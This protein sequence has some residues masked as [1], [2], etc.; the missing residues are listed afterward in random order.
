[1]AREN[2]PRLALGPRALCGFDC[3]VLSILRTGRAHTE[4]KTF[5]NKEWRTAREIGGVRRAELCSGQIRDQISDSPP[6]DLRRQHA[7]S[8]ETDQGHRFEFLLLEI[9]E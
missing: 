1:M 5:S 2:G 3:R 6:P 8:C 7:S 4:H 9:S